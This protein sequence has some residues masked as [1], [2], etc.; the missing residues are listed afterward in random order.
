MGRIQVELGT[1]P[2]DPFGVVAIFIVEMDVFHATVW[3]LGFDNSNGAKEYGGDTEG[4][5]V[6]RDDL[7]RLEEKRKE[8]MVRQ[9][10]CSMRLS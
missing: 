1:Q 2:S 3:R 4:R 5:E 7:A 6:H 9:N 10:L 8:V